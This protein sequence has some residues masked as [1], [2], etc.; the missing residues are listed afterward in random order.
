MPV[1]IVKMGGIFLK[2]VF[3]KGPLMLTDFLFDQVYNFSFA[4]SY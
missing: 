2:T 4:Y 1:E 3:Y